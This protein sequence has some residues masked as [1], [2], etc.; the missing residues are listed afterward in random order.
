[1]RWYGEGKVRSFTAMSATS[2][3][4]SS[5]PANA[6]AVNGSAGRAHRACGAV[7]CVSGKV[8]TPRRSNSTSALRLL[9]SSGLPLAS[10]QPS[11]SHTHR[12][13]ALRVSPDSAATAPRMRS[14][15]DAVNVC[16]NSRMGR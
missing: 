7:R 1:M 10:C 3:N 12:D 9:T 4:S 8:I 11:H 6:G 2:P 5:E 15:V 16:P 14:M 13:K